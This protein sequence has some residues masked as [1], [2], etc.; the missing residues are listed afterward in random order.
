MTEN[1]IDRRRDIL[2]AAGLPTTIRPDIP[3]TAHASVR[4][5]PLLQQV[6]PQALALIS[7]RNYL[8]YAKVAAESFLT[9]HKQF[10]AFL[11]LLDGTAEDAYLFPEGTVITLDDLN[12]PD[13]GW[14]AAK[15]TASEFCN[16]LKPVFL[17]YLASFVGH[18][19]YLDSDIAIFGPLN[20][21]TDL[22]ENSPLI[23]VPHMLKLFPRPERYWVQ[24]RSADIFHSGL[25]NAGCF[26]MQLSRC[27]DF[28]SFWEEAN[29][30]PGAFYR[31]AGYQTDQQHLNW[32]LITVPGTCVL[33][34][35]RYNVAYW[36]LHERNLRITTRRDGKRFEVDGRPLG[37][38]HFSGYDITDRLTIS[39]YDTR[40]SVYNLPAVAEILDW[41]SDRLL[42]SSSA[43]LLQERYG[44]DKFANGFRS[45]A[46]IRETLKK[47]EYY[48][49]KFDVTTIAGADGLCGFLMDPLPATGSMLPLVAAEIY[50]A[51][52]DLR[53]GYPDAHT[54]LNSSIFWRWFCRHAGAE[55]GV[56]FLID[57]FRRSLIS[58]SACGFAEV[59]IVILAGSTLQ[60]LGKDRLDAARCLRAKGRADIAETLLEAQTEWCFFTDLSA[61]LEIY[62]RRPSLHAQFPD[63]LGT[64]HGRF[65]RWLDEN[66]ASEHGCP[67]SACEEFRR[68]KA[69][70]CLGRIYS[71]LAR[72]DQLAEMCATY[73]LSDDPGPLFRE[74]IRSSGE[75]LEYDLDDVV[76]FRFIHHTCRHLLVPFYLELPFVRQKRAASRTLH[77]NLQLLPEEVR[78]RDWAARG[79]EIHAACFNPLDA[80]VEDEMRSLGEELFSETRN[81]LG[82]LRA[83][84]ASE[85][86]VM[87]ARN[88]RIVATR[89]LEVA[90]RQVPD[91]EVI[92]GRG[93]SPVAGPQHPSVNLFGYFFSEIGVGESSRGLARAIG[94][95][96][97]V[98]RIP[99]YT[100]QLQMGVELPELF[101]RY[102][103]YSDTNVFVS[104][105]HQV[106]D[107]LGMMRPE[108][109]R[110]RRNIAHLAWEQAQANPLWRAVYDRYDE[111]WVV[112]EF[113]ATPFRELFPDRVKVVPNVLSFEEFPAYE[114]YERNTLTR[115]K[116]E[117]LFVFDAN[118]SIER[119]NPE[120]LLDAF[121]KAFKD[122]LYKKHVTLT[123]KV[124]A[125]HRAEHKPRLQH[126][127]RTAQETGLDIRFRRKAT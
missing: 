15:F 28:L 42:S 24:P 56:Q 127:M 108:S 60:F 71:Y 26:A 64:D 58:D 88:A 101:Q 57:S 70:L 116:V 66:A 53:D 20:E 46:F 54:R 103:F 32:A 43:S 38:F 59:I 7:T 67:A 86:A 125:M 45:N 23:L 72:Q 100:G 6:V 99:L 8:P 123:F 87:S 118:S 76:A 93:A 68:H 11:L 13:A 95:L 77:L 124:G 27:L 112:S 69:A 48:I 19:V 119:K 97:P 17:K 33:R 85:T 49:P 10:A 50:E 29:L 110:G 83:R 121:I 90:D 109:R 36:N 113:A 16:A 117:F 44:F 30:A 4:R 35:S 81:V 120:G 89:R 47:Y 111:I 62:I 2:R 94:V 82:V 52:H 9:H 104:Y 63:I 5:Q 79:A 84:N 73:L 22:L 106:E 37:F 98:N 91:A 78:N 61:I 107:L 115:E 1:T 12:L 18:V 21:L 65:S 126:L 80:A 34:D 96:R 41:Y 31:G 92:Y 114:G 25:I 3:N 39:K 14:Y 102:E 51:R 122:T 40:Y 55:Y 74:L 75:G 105:P